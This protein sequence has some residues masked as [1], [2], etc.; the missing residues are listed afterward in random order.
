MA[1]QPHAGMQSNKQSGPDKL[2]CYADR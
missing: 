2:N 1:Y